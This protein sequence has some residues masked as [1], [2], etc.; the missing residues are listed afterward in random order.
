MLPAAVAAATSGAGL[1]GAVV[2]PG[3][4]ILV[5]V[6]TAGQQAEDFS[7]MRSLSR[8]GSKVVFVSGANNLIFGAG[9]GGIYDV[10]VRDLTAGTTTLVSAAK[11][12]RHANGRAFKA[13]ISADGRFV[14]FESTATNVV[15]GDT[16]GLTDVFVRNLATAT[17]TLVSVAADGSLA[18]GASG[19]PSISADGRFVAF[20][21]AASNLAGSDTNGVD[22]IFVRDLVSG[23]TQ[24]MSVPSSGSETDHPSYN[25]A[26]SLDG[27]FVAFTSAAANL[28][29]SDTNNRPDVFVRD[30]VSQSTSRVSVATGN[31]QADR[32]G[33]DPAISAHGRYV[34]FESSSD[35]LVAHDTN[36]AQDVFLHDAAS[37]VT[38]RV[39]VSSTGQQA[40]TD[41]VFGRG[42]FSKDPSI[43]ADGRYIAFT[44][45]ALN[46]VPCCRLNNPH[47]HDQVFLRDR[48]Q[49][50]TEKMSVNSAGVGSPGRDSEDPVISADGH[51]VGFDSQAR[52]FVV[53]DQNGRRADVFVHAR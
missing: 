2:S 29:P 6:N 9:G 42:I 8:D 49:G 35:N 30:R 45:S 41:T 11:G 13:A 14:A 37:G 21:S 15:A 40:G 24:R 44:S 28:V 3:Q 20:R 16:N 48:V 50:V 22:D 51:I 19:S 17:T 38:G 36:R 10:F 53:P 7:R 4:T 12:G 23:Q 33:N 1:G 5:S 18:D 47:V 52:N 46:L 34:A 27:R 25:P 31:L 26:I 39:S 43:S 32:G